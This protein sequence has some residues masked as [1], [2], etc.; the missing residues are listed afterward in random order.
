MAR[1]L[2]FDIETYSNVDLPKCGVYRYIEGDF[3]I[4]LLAYAF[5]DEEPRIIDMANGEELPQEVTDA[6]FDPDTIKSAW[7]AQFERTCM[8]KYF[9]RQLSPDSWRCSMVHAASLSLPLR[10]EDAALVLKTGEK[11]DKLGE[12]LIRYFSIPCKPTKTNGGRTR[13]LPEHDPAKWQLFKEYCLQDVRTERAI[14]KRLEQYPLPEHEWDYYHMDQRINDRGVMIDHKLVEQAIACD[15]IL[16][17]VMTQKAYE[18]TGLENPNS[19]SQ[20]K[21]WL[22]ERGIP[23]D[24]LGKKDVAALITDLDKHST[25][26]EALDMLKLRLQMAKSSVKKYQAAD[27]YIC[28]DS[29]ARGLFQFSGA[30]RTQRW[31]GRGIQLQNLPQNHIST[32]DEARELLKMGAFDVM[33]MVYDNPPD[34]LS[35]LCRTML[36]PKPGC[37]FVIADY[38]A[39]EA[40]VLAWLAG[41]EWRI[42]AFNN[43]EDIYCASASQMFGVPVVK[44]GINGEL[45]QKGKVAELACGYGGASGALISMGALDMGLKEEDLPEIINSWRTANPR[46]VQFWWDVEKAAVNTVKDHMERKVGRIGFQYHRSTLW[47]VLP[48]GRKLAYINPQMQPNRF[49]RMAITYEGVGANNKWSRGE[50]YSGKLVENVTQATARDLL[51]ESMWRMEQAGMDIVGHVHDEVILEVP[52]GSVT[53]EDAVEIMSINPAWADGLPL[54]AAGYYGPNFYFKD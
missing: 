1:I 48:S 34:I 17:E 45:R 8:G 38:S 4:L 33:A 5:D 39:I 19:V 16:S 41:E 43:G 52:V 54:N 44:H 24:S 14:R 11:K 50:T 18:L 9:G 15:T 20:L 21:L 28:K 3:H 30:N 40:R 6:F 31:S 13:N 2:S 32:L 10:L 53:V 25:D 23:M 29:R 49:G 35:Q 47:L 7:N 36:I 12:E 46:I 37:Q 42:T 26:Q 27:R 51:A 22:D